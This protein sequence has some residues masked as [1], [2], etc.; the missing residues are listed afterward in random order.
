MFYHLLYPLSDQISGLNLFRYITFRSA[1]AAITALLIS[2]IIGPWIIRQLRSL[3]I[4]EEIR[5]DGPQSHLT[6][7]GTPTMGGLII[8]A[9]II[10]PTLLWA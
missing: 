5:D 10:I 1:G 8:L 2:F 4:R 3:Q 6:K 9:A 7:A